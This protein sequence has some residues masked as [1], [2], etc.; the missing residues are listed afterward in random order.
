MKK[1]LSYPLTAIFYIVF[2]LLL[3]IFHGIQVICLNV[4]GYS[5][6]KRSVEI[7]NYLIIKSFYIVGSRIRFKGFEKIPTGRPLIIVSNHQSAWD[8]PPVVWGFRR[9]HPKFISKAELAKNIPSVSYNLRHGGSAIID[10]KN[11][12]QAIRELIKLGER[13]EKNKWAVCIFPEGT[14][15]EKGKMKSFQ[16]GGIRTLLKAV[17]SA[18]IVPFVIDGNWKLQPN[19]SALISVGVTLNYTVLDPIEPANQT[20]EELVTNIETVIGKALGQS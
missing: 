2:G 19:K 10:R 7:L 4:W 6:H 13:V 8:I 1:L 17:P 12:S 11:G 9:H 20:A 15:S 14:R 18:I 3:L 16:P 5:A